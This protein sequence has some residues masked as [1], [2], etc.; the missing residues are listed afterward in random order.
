MQHLMF[1]MSKRNTSIEELK[2]YSELEGH[3]ELIKQI[4]SKI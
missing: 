4:Y 1:L 3:I 2:K